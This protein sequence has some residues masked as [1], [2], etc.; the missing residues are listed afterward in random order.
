M[1]RKLLTLLFL[2]MISVT[3]GAQ[4]LVEVSGQVKDATSKVVLEFC[5][6]RVLTLND[7]LISGA[8]TDLKGYYRV[9][10][11]KGKYKFVF[12]YL[13]YKSD[14]ISNISIGADRFLG[15]VK[16]KL[17]KKLLKEVA[18]TASA[19]TSFVD[20]EQYIVTDKLREGTMAAKE[21]LDKIAGV[22]LDVLTDQ[23]KVDGSGKVVLLVDG[24][25]KNSDYVNTIAPERI[26]KIEVIKNPSGR[27]GM[28]GY[29]AVINIIL[30][31]DYQGFNIFASN[32]AFVD[33]DAVKYEYFVPQIRS[34]S[35]FNYVY[36]K[37]NLYATYNIR[38]DDFHFNSTST[39]KAASGLTIEL[40]NP[41]ANDMNMFTREQTNKY[42]IGVDYYFNPKHS[43]GFESNIENKP[44]KKDEVNYRNL[45]MINGA[46]VLSD[47]VSET[48]NISD[49]KYFSNSLF[50]VGKLD[51][52]NILSS[53]LTVANYK[54]IYSNKYFENSEQRKNLNG[55]D[56]KV[57]TTYYF[58]Y[59]HIF[60]RGSN[61]NVGYGN[62]T[63]NLNKENN[64]NGMV[65]SFNY[66]ERRNKM[67][68][69]YSFKQ[70]ESLSL[71]L[72]GAAESS[73][74]NANGLKRSYLIFQ[75]SVDIFYKASKMASLNLKYRR[76]TLY[77]NISHTNPY[78]TIIDKQT[79]QIGNPQLNPALTHKGALNLKL[80]QG[81]I[82]LEPYF[83]FSSNYI[84]EIATFGMD[85]ILNLRFDNVGKYTRKGILVNIMMPLPKS[86]VF[87]AN[88]DLFDANI[89]YDNNT[90][91]LKNGFVDAKLFYKD[92]KNGLLIGLMYMKARK[93]ITTQ[94]FQKLNEDFIGLIMQNYF[95][96]KKFRLEILYFL[97]I[98]W[99]IDYNNESFTKT[100]N[101]Q[102]SNNIDL[103]ILKNAFM[104]KLNYQFSKGK[105]AKILKK[106]NQRKVEKI[107]K[108]IL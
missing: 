58:E 49:N 41:Y 74:P 100:H 7:S 99:G 60:R 12:H 36:K 25:K 32:R 67:Y 98:E 84:S 85:S 63:E 1:R 4:G 31:K 27:F 29:S 9:A 37:L 55:V 53:N 34:E 54:D 77:P 43:L 64:T 6:I 86:M 15:V 56:D 45:Y 107:S 72:G 87:M 82:T 108:K 24:M 89:S 21:V 23:I 62:T 50:Y 70:S 75:P 104:V 19:Q 71:K 8:A 57:S 59:T 106:S 30:Y 68:A 79:T 26:R 14:T 61:F 13:G 42:S 81:M 51:Q 16:L 3:T 38:V 17:D 102:T 28:E 20:R 33:P 39:R 96:K 76:A 80:L 52:N 92:P 18:V 105:T 78:L 95:F 46:T 35:S 97:P 66:L 2:F 103:G 65:S 101:Y 83:H 69:S 5:N 22:S 47:F 93:E 48:K 11:N 10:L 40:T 94:G 88:I 91:S 73:N 90:N 44:D